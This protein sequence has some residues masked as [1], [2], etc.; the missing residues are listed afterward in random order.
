MKHATWIALVGVLLTSATVA[1][2]GV[3]AAEMAALGKK[4]EKEA[5]LRL[6]DQPPTAAIER[7]I[8]ALTY[9]ENSIGPLSTE[10]RRSRKPQIGVFVAVKLLQP[11]LMADRPVIA[12]AMP[13][14]RGVHSR[15]ARYR[16]LPNYTKAQLKQ[17]ELPAKPRGNAEQ[18]LAQVARVERNRQT[19]M[20][21][22][23]D[24]VWYNKQAVRLEHI[25]YELMLYLEDS[26]TDRAIVQTIVKAERQGDLLWHDLVEMVKRH[27]RKLDPARAEF[28]YEQFKELGER[29]KWKQR[30]YRDMDHAKILADANSSFDSEDEKPLFTFWKAANVLATTAKKPALKIPDEKKWK[31]K[32]K[33]MKKGK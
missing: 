23:Q 21:R 14:V 11:L 28:F 26:N 24:V 15:Y 16:K 32:R 29:N 3:T 13:V 33:A 8:K 12:K 31:D 18:V 30:K 17:F 1:S 25:Y 2:A 22:E 5:E 4:L 6:A 20:A 7:E 10:L 27:A 9:D 19:K